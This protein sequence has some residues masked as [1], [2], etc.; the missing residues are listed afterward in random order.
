M[1][2]GEVLHCA[3]SCIGNLHTEDK[4][5]CLDAAQQKV[6]VEFPYIGSIDEY[7]SVVKSL[8]EDEKFKPFFHVE[9]GNVSREREIVDSSG[10]ARRID[11]L[12]VTPAEARVIDYKSSKDASGAQEK[13]IAE[14]IDIVKSIYPGLKIRGFLIYLDTLEMDE[15]DGQ[16]SNIQPE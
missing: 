6:R 14:Y 11:R 2:R 15:V 10:N 1:L 5:L 3:L 12:I 7:I 16:S 4:E 8:V 13:Q 9:E